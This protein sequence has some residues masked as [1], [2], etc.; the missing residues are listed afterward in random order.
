VRTTP[1]PKA[2]ILKTIKDLLENN[3][4][5][6]ESFTPKARQCCHCGAAILFVDSDLWLQGTALMRNV[7]LPFCPVCEPEILQDQPVPE[8]I[9]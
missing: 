7:P 4:L 9:H 5:D 3:L 2:Q 1:Q 8:T 6:R